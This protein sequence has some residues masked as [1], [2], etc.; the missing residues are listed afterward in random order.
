MLKAIGSIFLL[1]GVGGYGVSL[2]VEYEKRVKMLQGIEQMIGVLCEYIAY[3]GATLQE[4]LKS[5]SNR[6]EEVPKEFLI[7]V[8]QKLEEKEG[9]GIEKVWKEAC[10][11]WEPYLEEEEWK[12][13]S[14]LFQKTG[15]LERKMQLQALEQYRRELQQSIHKLLEQKESKCRVYYTLGVMSGLFF[16]VLL[17]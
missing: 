2:V 5:T 12:K 1:M 16:C 3:E 8:I 13:L 6:V 4:A 14:V 15:Y 10:E 17:W 11:V 9:V 7:K